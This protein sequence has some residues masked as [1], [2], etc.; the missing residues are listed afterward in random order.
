[1]CAGRFAR[2]APIAAEAHLCY[3]RAAK[4]GVRLE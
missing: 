1:M 3:H 2:A 4:K